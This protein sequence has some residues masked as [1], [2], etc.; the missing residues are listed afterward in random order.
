[1]EKTGVCRAARVASGP[2]LGARVV[3][4]RPVN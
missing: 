1:L 3:E 2:V 4:P